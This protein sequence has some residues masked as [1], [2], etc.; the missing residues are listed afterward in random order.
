MD[1]CPS[2]EWAVGTSN[3]GRAATAGGVDKGVPEEDATPPRAAPRES[4]LPWDVRILR[5]A[6]VSRPV[7]GG[8]GGEAVC[9][10]SAAGG[11][12]R[13]DIT[14]GTAEIQSACGRCDV[15]RGRSGNGSAG[16]NP[17]DA[18]GTRRRNANG[19]NNGRLSPKSHRTMGLPPRTRLRS[20]VRGHAAESF[21]RFSATVPAVTSHSG[22]LLVPRRRTV[23]TTAARPCVRPETVSVSG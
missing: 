14:N 23:A 7:G 4:D 5:Q 16:P 22:I 10:R 21:R 12:R 3:G 6:R 15:G 9:G 11:F 20:L 8:W 2:A 19:E 13:S 1:G 18:S 17:R